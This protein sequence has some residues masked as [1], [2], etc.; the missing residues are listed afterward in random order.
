MFTCTAHTESINWLVN[1]GSAHN[2]GFTN[3]IFM[4]LNNTECLRT[5]SLYIDGLM[6]YNGY[7]V[8][9]LIHFDSSC[10]NISLPAI[11]EVSIGIY[12]T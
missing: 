3:A 9:C 6:E 1:G 12:L 4:E 2:Q 11:L 5:S 7:I 8:Q 10:H